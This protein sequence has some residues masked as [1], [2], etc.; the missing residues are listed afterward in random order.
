MKLLFDHNLSPK[1]VGRLV[2][3]FPG[4]THVAMHG[5]DAA[6]DEEIWDFAKSNDLAIVTK[7][8]DYA[9][10]EVI[11]GFPPKVLWLQIGNCT[12]DEVEQL[13]KAQ[14]VTIE[15]FGADPSVGTLTLS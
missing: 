10:M 3:E 8:A 12:N 13:L 9:D 7:D 4:S 6:T 11:R 5:L 1:L 14:Q 2:S 15:S